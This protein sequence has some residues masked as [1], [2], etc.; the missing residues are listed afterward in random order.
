[1]A[2]GKGEQTGLAEEFCRETL[3]VHGR[4]SFAF[5]DQQLFSIE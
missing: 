2:R 5:T 1:M 3:G 4:G